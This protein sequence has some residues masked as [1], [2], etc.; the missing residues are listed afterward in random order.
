VRYNEKFESFANNKKDYFSSLSRLDAIRE[1]R[2]WKNA[3]RQVQGEKEQTQEEKK[4]AQREK[5][6]AQEQIRKEIEQARK[7]MEAANKLS[8]DTE[9]EE[10]KLA[11]RMFESFANNKKDY[12]SSLSRLDAIREERTWKNAVRR[13]REEREQAWKQA[14]IEKKQ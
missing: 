11:F 13:T 3:V 6:Q 9:A 10:V 1:E 5:E 8:D 14:H 4:Q 2:T 12:F 7:D